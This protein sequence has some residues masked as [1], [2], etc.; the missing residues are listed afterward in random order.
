[1]PVGQRGFDDPVCRARFSSLLV[2]MEGAVRASLLAAAAPNSGCWLEALPSPSLGLRL[3]DDELRV[4]VGL[5]VG[6][7]VV[8]AHVCSCGVPVAPDGFHGL[9]CHR[10]A[11]RASRHAS[12]NNILAMALRSAG[13]PTLLEPGGLLPGDARRPDGATMIPWDHG[14]CLAWDYTCPDTVA[15]SHLSSSTIAA[16]LVAGEAESFKSEKYS[17]LL[18]SHVFVPVAIEILGVWGPSATSLVAEIGRRLVISSGDP[19][20]CMFLRQRIGMAMQR[21]N[22]KSV[23][24]TISLPPLRGEG[25]LM[26]GFD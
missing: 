23:F 9:C 11:G 19:R 15:P 6:G 14:R 2:G 3:G 5:R 8:S 12:I 7:P 1:M 20:S 24:G 25:I 26:E 18:P 16:G 4:A 10:S 13:V 17:D 21:G 22:S